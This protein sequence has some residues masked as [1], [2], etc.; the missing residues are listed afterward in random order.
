M[1]LIDQATALAQ[2]LKPNQA[3]FFPGDLVIARS[4]TGKLR[5]GNGWGAWWQGDA[6]ALL[7]EA[8]E[9][10][11]TSKYVYDALAFRRNLTLAIEYPKIF[12]VANV[13]RRTFHML[14]RTPVTA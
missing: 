4:S 9:A 10:R 13:G 2:S 3:T 7:R 14:S 12:P 1:E 8:I 6:E 5:A 11:L